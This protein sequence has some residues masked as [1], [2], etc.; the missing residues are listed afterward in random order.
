[1]NHL[2]NFVNIDGLIWLLN[3]S[4]ILFDM[5]P[6]RIYIL[7]FKRYQ[8]INIYQVLYDEIILQVCNWKLGHYP[9][10][11]EFIEK[12]AD[13]Y[14]RVSVEVRVCL[15]E[16]IKTLTK[17]IID[18]LCILEITT[19]FR[20]FGEWHHSWNLLQ[21]VV[22]RLRLWGRYCDNMQSISYICRSKYLCIGLELGKRNRLLNFLM[23]N[24]KLR[25]P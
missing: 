6:L 13:K 16:L 3:V 12:H 23:R 20:I 17:F 18:K 11:K 2:K 25:L 5:R 15:P 14:T 7:K 21:M 10:T 1:M 22:K 8:I 19:L 4:S 9:H 24:W